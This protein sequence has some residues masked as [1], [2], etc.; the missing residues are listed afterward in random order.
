M[1]S[2]EALTS[3]IFFV[4]P[5][6]FCNAWISPSG[7]RVNSI[8]L[9]SAKYSLFLDKANWIAV[10]IIGAKTTKTSATIYIIN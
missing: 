6:T 1:D 3:F 8:A 5:L 4:S 7:F 10:A 2:L 9:A